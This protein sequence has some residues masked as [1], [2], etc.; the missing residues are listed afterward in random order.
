MS[1]TT[2][3][4]RSGASGIDWGSP[5]APEAAD[6][7]LAWADLTRGAYL[8]EPAGP[9]HLLLTLGESATVSS[10]RAI[11]GIRVPRAYPDGARRCTATVPFQRE[12]LSTL[13]ALAQVE[14]AEPGLAVPGRPRRSPNATRQ[15]PGEAKSAARKPKLVIGII[16]GPAGWLNRSFRVGNTSRLACLW[17]Q[18]PGGGGTPPAG[19]DF[20]TEWTGDMLDALLALAPR[21]ADEAALYGRHGFPQPE[22]DD[23]LSHGTHILDLIL[24]GGRIGKDEAD[25]LAE[26]ERLAQADVVYVQLPEAALADTGGNWGTLVLD[27]LHYILGVAG[28]DSAVVVNLSLGAFAGPHDGSSALER[29]IDAC[30]AEREAEGRPKLHVV[31]ASGNAYQVLDDDTGKEVPCHARVE[32]APGQSKAIGWLIPSASDSEH[33]VECRVDGLPGADVVPSGLQVRLQMPN[34][35][36]IGTDATGAAALAI[37]TGGAPPQIVGALICSRPPGRPEWVLAALGGSRNRDGRYVPPGRW[38]L[39]L[40]NTNESATLVVDLWSER[41]DLPGGMAG[42]PRPQS[43]F[44]RGSALVSAQDTLAS[45]AGG[46]K[47]IVVGAVDQHGDGFVA[48]PYASAGPGAAALLQPRRSGS[49]SGPDLSAIGRQQAAGFYSGTMVSMEG[50]SMAAALVTRAVALAMLTAPNGTRLSRNDILEWLR[51]QPTTG[52]SPDPER[53][54][55]FVCV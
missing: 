29:A 45:L 31:V 46:L 20:G 35:P 47:T 9:L 6:P 53:C 22:E 1:W 10:V 19:F 16:D 25:R 2:S 32:L 8:A 7:Y 5:S 43:G 33:F 18:N 28:D 12:A 11:S 23:G 41:R 37:D 44:P 27:G 21:R 15:P 55:A 50:T 14:F 3:P 26:T 52:G 54:G 51:N 17:N 40:Q 39:T 36:Q 34:G 13:H 38:E 42:E 48:S 30:I 49:R 4:L 24:T